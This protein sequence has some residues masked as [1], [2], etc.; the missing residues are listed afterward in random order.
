MKPQSNCKICRRLMPQLA[1]DFNKADK[2]KNSST[3]GDG[4]TEFEEGQ[5][6]R[7][8]IMEAFEVT[9]KQ[10]YNFNAMLRDQILKS[11]YFKSLMNIDTFEGI[12]NELYKSSHTAEVYGAGSTAGS[13]TLPSTLFCC[14]FRFFTL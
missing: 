3:N 14:I 7:R 5:S 12:V 8:D 1:P 4:L 13:T 6:R 10:T 9:N 2:R 11:T